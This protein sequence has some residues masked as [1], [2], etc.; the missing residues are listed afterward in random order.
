[1]DTPVEGLGFF[2]IPH[3]VSEKQRI[4]ASLALIRVMEGEIAVQ[5]VISELERLIEGNWSWKVEEGDQN[6][7]RTFFPSKNELLHMVEWG[8]GGLVQS[9]SNNAKF[10][11][12]ESLV[13]NEVKYVLPKV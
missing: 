10:Q 2:H 7:F 12:E 11:I 1:V 5:D 6:M 13:D 4:D 9:K 3:D 8:G